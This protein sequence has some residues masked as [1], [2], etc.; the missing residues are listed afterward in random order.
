MALTRTLPRQAYRHGVGQRRDAALGRRVAFRVFLGLKRPGGGKVHHTAPRIE[1][2]QKPL[3]QI[4][5]RRHA[6][7]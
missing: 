6:Y 4:I 7:L 1:I 3:G 2:G 5:G